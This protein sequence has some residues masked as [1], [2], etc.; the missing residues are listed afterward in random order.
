MIREQITNSSRLSASV[1]RYH[2]WPTLT[3]QTVAEHSYHVM[4]IFVE[5][6]T[7]DFIFSGEIAK[8][9]LFHD[10]GEMATGDIPFPVK[11]NNPELKV[12][13][14]R[15]EENHRHTLD[16][17][18]VRLSQDTVTAIKICDLLEMAEFGLHEL[19]LGN[20]YAK[21]IIENTIEHIWNYHDFW[22]KF[23]ETKWK[24]NPHTSSMLRELM[25]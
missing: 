16:L 11:S 19:R 8:C 1:K 21:P 4:R 15:L 14:D 25:T 12:I 24:V 17:P 22:C 20:Q 13:L 7:K 10:I 5:Y 6:M 2:T 23:T 9:I 3:Q 18:E